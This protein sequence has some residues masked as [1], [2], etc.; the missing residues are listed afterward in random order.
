MIEKG[1]KKSSLRT[2][3]EILV[4]A[5]KKEKWKAV[6]KFESI[7]DIREMEKV[8]ISLHALR[9]G[10]LKENKVRALIDVM[11]YKLDRDEFLTR[12]RNIYMDRK[13]EEKN[14]KKKS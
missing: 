14:K 3:Y 5:R 8:L 4:H 10:S 13:K 6:K 7:K 9:M 12:L 2:Y 1:V 11:P